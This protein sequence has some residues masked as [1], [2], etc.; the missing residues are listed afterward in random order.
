MTLIDVVVFVVIAGFYLYSEG[1]DTSRKEAGVAIGVYG[2][3]LV[4]YLL[5]NPFPMATSKSIGQ[6]YGFLPM[7]SFGAIL[8]PHFNP[9]SPEVVTRVMGWFGLT[10]AFLIL[11]YFK[12][13]VW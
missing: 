1:S 5:I 10:T 3:Y 2:T 6:L 12:L 13:F 7:L 11:S 8:F 9:S 4:I